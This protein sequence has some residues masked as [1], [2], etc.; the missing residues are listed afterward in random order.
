[1]RLDDG[2][3]VAV[4]HLP[5]HAIAQ[6]AGIRHEHIHATELGLGG[7]H[8]LSGGLGRPDGGDHRDR[9]SARSMDVGDGLPGGVGIDVVDHDGGS[10]RREGE[11]VRATEAAARTRDDGDLAVEADGRAHL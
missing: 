6:H 11:R 3:E 5:Q 9:P 7:A 2:V 8:E 1:M 4:L 10:G